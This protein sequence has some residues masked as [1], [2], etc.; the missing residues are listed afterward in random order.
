MPPPSPGRSIMSDIINT[1]HNQSQGSSPF[2]QFRKVRPDGTE[3][4]SARDL[5]EPFGYAAWRE[6]EKIVLLGAEDFLNLTG[7]ADE[8]FVRTHKMVPIGSGAFRQ[9]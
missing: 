7:N 1:G 5:R 3:Y 4:W 9:L 2:D 8:H 6:F